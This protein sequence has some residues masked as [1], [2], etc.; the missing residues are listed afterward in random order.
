MKQNFNIIRVRGYVIG[1]NLEIRGKL[2]NTFANK[3]SNQHQS[4]VFIQNKIFKRVYKTSN[5]ES[6]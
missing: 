6:K 2:V 1:P 5:C 3:T 4:L